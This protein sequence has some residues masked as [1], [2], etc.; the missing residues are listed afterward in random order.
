MKLT[1]SEYKAIARDALKGNWKKAI[2]ATVAAACMGAFCTSFY[3]IGQFMIVMGISIRIFE[4]IPYYFMTLVF[5]G[6]ILAIFFF[7]AGGPAKFGYINFNLALLDR[8]PAKISMVAG[9][10]SLIWKGI[11]MKIALFFYEFFFTL[12]LIVPGIVTMYSYAMVPYILE[13]KPN[14][15]VSKAMRMSR[16]IMRGHKWQLFCLRLSFI[17]WYFIGILTVGIAFFY[18][19]PYM[20]AAEAV[21][22][23]EISGR[24]DVFYG[25]ELSDRLEDVKES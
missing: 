25:R 3:F 18:V 15:T 2:G 1:S 8:R 12:L 13:E 24:A 5:L 4:N 20:N 16:K 23:N 7:F 17:G 21:F 6:I 19:F 10:F 22:Y 11:Y 9:R 14:Y